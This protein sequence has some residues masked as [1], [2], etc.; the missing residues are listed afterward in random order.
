MH[1]VFEYL[2][3]VKSIP[4][5]CAL[6]AVIH[7]A[8][9]Q[10]LHNH[11]FFIMLWA[12][13]GA[14]I[15]FHY[16]TFDLMQWC[17]SFM[18]CVTIRIDKLLKDTS[19]SVGVHVVQATQNIA[20]GL[21]SAGAQMTGV[22]FKA[23]THEISTHKVGLSLCAKSILDCKSVPDVTS[24]IGKVCSLL[25]LEHSL[26]ESFVGKVCSLGGS[27]LSRIIPVR[28]HGHDDFEKF[29]PLLASAAAFTNIELGG[30]EAKHMDGF[31]RNLRSAET[32]TKH[33]R[34]LAES[35][36]FLKTKNWAILEE[37]NTAV[38][39][40]KA[41]HLWIAET[42]ALRGSDFCR[43]E[44]WKRVEAYKEK[45]DNLSKRLRS[46]NLPEIKNNQIVV[47]VNVIQNKMIDYLNQIKIIRNS[48]GIRPVPV[49]VCIQGPSQIGKS[50]IVA[51]IVKRVK[52]KL[53][54]RQDLFGETLGWSQWDA[55]QREEF[56][57]GY[58]GQEIVNM[59]DAFQDKTN[60]DHLMWYT[61]ISPTCVGTIQ[62]VAEQKGLPFRALLCLTTCNAMP[63][64]SI[65]VEHIAALHERF[66]L[67]YKVQ[68]KENVTVP[69]QWDPSFDHLNIRYGSMT[70][71]VAGVPER[72][73]Q[74]GNLATSSV[75]D[76]PETNLDGIVDQIV[77]RMIN[78]MTFFNARMASMRQLPIQEHGLSDDEDGG[79]F[80]FDNI[81]FERT[82]HSEVP[83]GYIPEETEEELAALTLEAVEQLIQ[84]VEADRSR[85]ESRENFRMEQ[86]RTAGTAQDALQVDAA[87]RAIA[88]NLQRVV[89]QQHCN[90]IRE[91][92][93][94]TQ[95][96]R[97]KDDRGLLT[98]SFSPNLFQGETGL[99]DFLSSL[100][101]W[102]VPSDDREAF[103]AAF[104]RQGLLK[105]EGPYDEYLWGPLLKN[106]KILYLIS[107]DLISK[108]DVAMRGFWKGT[109]PHR[110]R[111]INSWFWS[112]RG[113]IIF[114]TNFINIVGYELIPPHPAYFVS[115]MLRS[116]TFYMY[117]EGPGSFWIRDFGWRGWAHNAHNTL[118]APLWC[119]ARTFDYFETVAERLKTHMLN[120]AIQ[121]LEFLGV[122]VEG[123]WR[124][125]ATLTISLAS[126]VVI[127]G[128]VAIL[129]FI[130]WKLMKL[131]FSPKTGKLE[132]HESKNEYGKMSRQRKNAKKDKRLQVRQ[133]K[134]R[135]FEELT[136]DDSCTLDIHEED[137]DNWY[138]VG[139][140]N[141]DKSIYTDKAI[142]WLLR[143]DQFD[144]SH[145]ATIIRNKNTH[146]AIRV[147]DI[148]DFH[149]EKTEFVGAKRI[150]MLVNKKEVFAPQIRFNIV[151]GIDEVCD[152]YIDYLDLFKDLDICDWEGDVDFRK[153]GDIF[154]VK[155][156][157]VGL[158]TIIQGKPQHFTRRM[159]KDLTSISQDILGLKERNDGDIK[160]A[161]EENGAADSIQLHRTL[162]DNHQVFMS[163]VPLT[164]LD[165][166]R[167]GKNTHGL[168]HLSQIIF[169]AHNYAVGDFVRFWRYKDKGS[170]HYQMCEVA[171]IDVI[172]D[173]GFAR[174]VG[175]DEM[176]KRLR[177]INCSAVNMSSVP[178]RFRSLETHLCDEKTWF[179]LAADQ[180]CLCFLPSS[181]IS[182]IG[183]SHIKGKT[184]YLING[185]S[186]V[187]DYVEVSQLNLS[188][189]LAKPGDCGGIV[190]SFHDRHQ[191]KLLGFHSGGTP[192]HWYAS[193]L[194]KEDLLEFKQHGDSDDKFSTLI[195]KG[196]PTDLPSGSEVT[197][198]GKYKFSTRPAGIKSLAH[199]SYSPFSEEFEE[200]LQP[201]PL[202][203]YDPR[204]KID[205]PTNQLGEKSLLL[206]PNGVM[207]KTLP[208]IDI[209]T[210]LL[211]EQQIIDEMSAKIGHITMLP[212]ALKDII[213][214]GLNGGRE[215]Q[216][217]TGMELDK[218][219]G[220]P[221]NE[222]PGCTKKSDFLQN[223]DG[224]ISFRD[225]ENGVKLLKRVIQK[226]EAAKVG[227]R[228]ISFSNSKLKDA[229][230]KISAVEQGKT[231]VFHCIPVD[232]VICDAA[233]FGDF[234]EAY[235]KAFISLNHAI[236]VNPHSNQ[237][238]A[239]YD[240]LNVH[241]NVFDMD[242]TNYDK[243]LHG[244][245]MRSVFNII[246][247]VI[248][249]NAPDEWD[250]ARGV[251]AEESI[252]TYVV[253]YDTVY[254][255]TRGNKSG[256]YLTTVV[257]CIAN[258]ILSFYTWVKVTGNQ[259]LAD[260]RDNVS[261][262]TF[263]DDKI[264]SVSDEYAEMYNY[265]SSKEVMTSI[266]HIIT[267][268]AKD[269]IERKFCPLEQAQFLKRGII[270]WEGL[271][272][273][274]LLQ[275]SIESPFVWTQIANS[276]H[277]IWR[278]L[279][280]QCMCE[281]L[282]H[283]E[284]YYDVFRHK[285]SR[286]QDLELRASLASLVAVPFK[287]AKRKYFSKYYGS[288]TH[289]CS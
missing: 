265:F 150:T 156:C 206:I 138:K 203:A 34:E 173:I 58:V 28:Q 6:L 24:E 195:V 229:Q 275:R 12:S 117:P 251:L 40:L 97:R 159:L 160:I 68:L 261:T 14:K 42:L 17:S 135:G 56:D 185:E 252:C 127:I 154:H 242:F 176:L 63:T 109:V 257:N 20:E 163:R 7:I 22:S 151:G 47:E 26:V 289:L 99:Y 219:C 149:L 95:Y 137:E 72:K 205:L 246:R 204:I 142:E 88:E 82:P 284:E 189:G 119:V 172:R 79:I 260:F 182:A 288:N 245:L 236:G 153:I 181:G 280:E 286:C 57:S 169:N 140:L 274:P 52:T 39:S 240:H 221:W 133:F 193:I 65:T 271:I 15:F 212:L 45:V 277:E 228:T 139:C 19:H 200:Q 230:I 166:E 226:L 216:F 170:P 210:L 254:E 249:R 161:F 155:V 94:W 186:E 237:W 64:K 9:S 124:D 247:Q 25:G 202:D 86:V 141:L 4:Y 196:S 49:G 80:D 283:G 44:N 211:A 107:D 48:I 106:G 158:T 114:N 183:R 84:S 74:N 5:A 128:L 111:L 70:S 55:N 3:G 89:Q 255:T 233:L 73:D 126:E 41:D 104:I 217:C 78:N 207:C 165:T 147:E 235:S 93:D 232:K 71:F 125:V 234:K 123:L 18:D 31:A 276:E 134:Q 267:P 118:C 144:E 83:E 35:L 190:M 115:H 136:C 103:D 110:L 187:R 67:T 270:M 53:R 76:W 243:H 75:N 21:T 282:L 116:L 179:S 241:P 287:V 215:N 180:S 100:G 168:G 13:L 192:S 36:G 91:V 102:Y 132:Q 145:H 10:W 148:D 16:V 113:Q 285:I 258:D 191:T 81:E 90:T 198:L 248:Q 197:F 253:D 120:V 37:L 184:A 164:E 27:Q 162:V 101:A 213:E 46:I 178:D 1:P 152:R 43:G 96:L 231:R 157:L 218:A 131:L 278:N 98:T 244:E 33:V 29:I 108:V 38:V 50:T 105:V 266:G 238:R 30:F 61:Y 8:V 167:V 62:G 209:E 227:K 112:R 279:T 146:I 87:L 259:N 256:E 92:G 175:K 220:L 188:V 2:V 174:I 281:A 77:E 272:I 122:S 194:K 51:E 59:D 177:E 130:F 201:G 69:K 11:G 60:K 199:W 239:I 250:V 143:E 54:T 32:I 224:I 85:M 262:I 121:L 225:D 268:G 269:G 208:S 263:G 223:D 171:R 264:E 66:P 214:R 273:A 23:I 222:L 129:L